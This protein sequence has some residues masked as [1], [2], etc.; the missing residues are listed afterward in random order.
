MNTLEINRI[1]DACKLTRD[2][3]LGCYPSDKI[4]IFTRFPS[5]C[6]IN[7]DSSTG[8][9][10]HWV[11]IF[12]PNIRHIFYFDSLGAMPNYNIS[13][14]LSSYINFKRNV[15]SYQSIFSNLCGQYCICFIYFLSLNPNY[16]NFL[17]LLSS[18]NNAD[19]FVTHFIK[20][21]CK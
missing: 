7:T 17:N 11:A 1:L 21:F 14:Y 9:G 6:V 3:Y 18:Y 20:N 15:K 16:K 4:P 13:K 12:A 10:T 2:S 5:S 8:E 19:F